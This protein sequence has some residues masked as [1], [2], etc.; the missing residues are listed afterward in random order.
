M[1]A[2][3]ILPHAAVQHVN[4]HVITVKVPAHH[5]FTHTGQYEGTKLTFINECL[6]LEHARAVAW[7]AVG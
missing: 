1:L 4:Q 5:R 3:L 7:E 6:F 2:R